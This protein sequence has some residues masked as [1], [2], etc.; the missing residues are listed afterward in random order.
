[1]RSLLSIAIVFVAAFGACAADSDKIS[2]YKNV[3]PIFQQNCQGCH[4]PAKAGGGYSMTVYADMLKKGDREKPGIVPGKPQLSF[5]VAL[6]QPSKGKAEMPRGKDPLP[7]PQIK[8]ITDWIAQ[9]AI[10]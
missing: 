10:D 5:L 7:E 6:I 8:T 3:R 1:M 2:Y 9:G 4:Q